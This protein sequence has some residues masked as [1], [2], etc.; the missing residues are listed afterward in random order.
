MYAYLMALAAMVFA[1]LS[2]VTLIATVNHFDS[3][4]PREAETV[5]RV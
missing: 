3:P 1:A 2:A 4:E 5:A